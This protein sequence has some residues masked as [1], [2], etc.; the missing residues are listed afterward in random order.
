MDESPEKSAKAK[1]F[2][3][4]LPGIYI[5]SVVS[6]FN[7][8]IFTYPF[9]LVKT[10]LQIQGESAGNLGL[11]TPYQGMT[12]TGMSIVRNEGF[13]KLW[14]GIEAIF[15]RQLIYAGVR[16]SSYKKIKEWMT[17]RNDDKSYF[18]LWQAIIG[19]K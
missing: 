10:R 16:V 14:K 17:S 1:H 15:L 13:S 3:N 8:E 9:D 4:T 11:S 6:A 19:K 18:P 7:A 12:Q 2:L 5:V